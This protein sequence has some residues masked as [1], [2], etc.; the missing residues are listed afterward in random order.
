MMKRV[1]EMMVVLFQEMAVVQTERQSQDVSV[2]Q[3]QLPIKH[4][5]VVLNEEMDV[6]CLLKDVMMAIKLMVMAVQVVV[7]KSLG[8]L[9]LVAPLPRGAPVL[10]IVEI[11][12]TWAFK[13]ETL[14]QVKLAEQIVSM[15]NDMND[16]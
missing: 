3:R 11:T 7:L 10:K 9:E 12:S 14:Y 6:K 4:P 1:V 5:T 2:V 15:T 13:N 8:L 16:L